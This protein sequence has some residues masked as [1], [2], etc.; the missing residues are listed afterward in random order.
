MPR[1]YFP[2]A[3]STLGAEA[4]LQAQE[5]ELRMQPS[6][7][8]KGLAVATSFLNAGLRY[9]QNS[10]ILRAQE[11]EKAAI[12]E[13]ERQEFIVREDLEEVTPDMPAGAK[14]FSLWGKQYFKR[15]RP[16]TGQPKTYAKQLKVLGDE[17]VV[18]DPMTGA[19]EKT[20]TKLSP[21][22]QRE[23]NKQMKIL[24]D[25]MGNQ[26]GL[27]F[28]PKTGEWKRINLSGGEDPLGIR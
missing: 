23:P 7:F 16:E 2:R 14:K 3:P 26:I 25:D 20:G 24:K 18:F 17:W 6:S 8:D 27:I 12:R 1:R 22:G 15:P 28:N 13:Q 9:K 11:A 5:N 19:S 10:D 21:E 4:M